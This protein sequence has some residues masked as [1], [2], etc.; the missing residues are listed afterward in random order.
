MPCWDG[1]R[2]TST[3]RRADA[4]QPAGCDVR[5]PAELAAGVE[6]GEDDLDPG[7]AG[8]R[9]LVD[10]DAAAVVV[11]LGG[12]VGVQGDLDQ[13]ARARERLVHTVVDD[14][15]QAVHQT[16]CV[17]GPD[18]HARTLA[19]RLE[20]LEHEEVC[21]V[22]GVVGDRGSPAGVGSCCAIDPTGD[23]P[24]GGAGTLPVWTAVLL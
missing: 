3:S 8:L 13:V 24:R 1:V 7:E 11:H 4:V 17:R 9:L 20:P 22:V 21:C 23:T 15:P 18:V 6:L 10:R 2:S 19:D 14:L 5:R 16:P 12:T